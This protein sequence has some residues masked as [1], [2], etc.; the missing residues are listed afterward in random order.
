MDFVSPAE[1]AQF[2]VTQNVISA[3]FSKTRR[4]QNPYT[5][6]KFKKIL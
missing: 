1:A 2:F 3:V 6:I 5:K 4:K